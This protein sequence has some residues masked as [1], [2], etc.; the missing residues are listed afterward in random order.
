MSVIFNQRILSVTDIA[1]TDPVV[2][3]LAVT[4]FGQIIL[5]PIPLT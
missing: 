3:L 4:N 2:T 1:V 5:T